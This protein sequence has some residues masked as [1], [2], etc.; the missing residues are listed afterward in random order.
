M[1][2][3]VQPTV[4]AAVAPANAPLPLKAV[5]AVVIGNWLEF[6]DFLVYTFFAVMI[7]DAFF[8]GQSAIGRLLGALATFGVG[9]F[10]RLG[11]VVIGAYADR[12]GRR[13]ALTLTLMLMALGSAVVAFTPSYAQIGIAAPIILVIA[14]LIQGFSCGGEVGP[15]T[16]YL[17]ESA[18][19]EKRASL[20]AWQGYSQQ[21]AILMGSLV[22]VVLTSTLNKAQLYAWGWRVP[23]V[24]GLVI[25]P[26]ALYIRRRLPETI[27][28]AETHE[29]GKAVLAN[30][31]RHHSRAVILGI[32]I[33]SGSTISTYVFNYMNTYAVTTLHLSEAIGTILTLT[34][35]VASIAGMAFGVWADRFGRKPLLVALRAIF[36]VMVYPAYL[37]LTS[38]TSTP[39]VITAVNMLLNFVFSTGIGALYAFLLEAFPK[40]VRSS[41]LAIMYALSVTIFGGTTQ[42]VVAWLID[43]TKNPLVPAWYQIIANVGSI[44]AIALLKAHSD[45]RSTRHSTTVAFSSNASIAE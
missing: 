3:D 29:S 33:I 28:K 42:F 37:V 25:A 15:A 10:T 13:A 2:I 41:G 22:G 38:P 36:V 39:V 14:R 35:A 45:T 8:P 24:L 32:F 23:F 20:T 7:A 21:L 26:L 43:F 4:G 12:A 1:R 31:V 44:I 11:A 9:F 5:V 19:P 30:L 40:S 27:Q 17:L 18:P 34:G 6:Y 16:T